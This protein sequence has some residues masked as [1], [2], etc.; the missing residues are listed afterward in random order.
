MC[1][2]VCVCVCVCVCLPIS[3]EE[4]EVILL[5]STRDKANAGG[6]MEGQQ[7]I[8]DEVALCGGCRDKEQAAEKQF[9]HLL[10]A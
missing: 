4:A 7:A 1:G 9:I 8:S 5:R 6:F 3:R 10:Q 2:C